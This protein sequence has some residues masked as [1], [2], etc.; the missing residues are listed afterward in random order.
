MSLP[1]GQT[2]LGFTPQWCYEHI[3]TELLELKNLYGVKSFDGRE[4]FFIGYEELDPRAFESPN[5][6][7]AV[8]KI[9]DCGFG[10]SPRKGSSKTVFEPGEITHEGSGTE[11]VELVG[12]HRGNARFTLE[13]TGADTYEL[14]RTPWTGSSWDDEE[15][16]SSGSIPGTNEIDVENGQT[17][18]INS[19]SVAEGDAYSWETEA[20]KV[21]HILGRTMVLT[22]KI[23]VYFWK[24]AEQVWE[25]NNPL[26]QMMCLF[27]Y[28]GW[29]VKTLGDDYVDVIEELTALRAFEKTFEVVRTGD[30]EGPVNYHRAHA[31]E[32]RLRYRGPEAGRDPGVF[33][34]DVE[35]LAQPAVEEVEIP[36]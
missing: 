2:V 34:V 33:N 36:D 16:V 9:T 31:V 26:D 3:R 35:P 20:Y 1:Y 30:E 10:E 8:I 29:R 6:P 15:V 7:A 17:F 18:K 12:S 25:A 21:Y 32:L 23:E 19:G 27:N 28:K 14:R 4:D 13:I 24:A 5:L 11:D 22:A